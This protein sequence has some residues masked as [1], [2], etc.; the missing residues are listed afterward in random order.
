[1]ENPVQCAGFFV[2]GLYWMNDCFE[3]KVLCC[4]LR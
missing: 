2:G 3:P 4:M 1:M